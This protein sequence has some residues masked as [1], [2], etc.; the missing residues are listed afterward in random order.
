MLASDVCVGCNAAV[1]TTP[2]FSCD[3]YALISFEIF[4]LVASLVAIEK[5]AFF[6]AT[7]PREV[8]TILHCLCGLVGAA[9]FVG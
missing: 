9:A 1:L 2:P 6:F 5:G 4:I 7:L 3:R 8:E